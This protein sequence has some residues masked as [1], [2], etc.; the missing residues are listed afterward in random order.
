VALA[1]DTKKTSTSAADSFDD[2]TDNIAKNDF[3]LTG[4]GVLPKHFAT[5][6]IAILE[7]GSRIRS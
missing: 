3:T 2:L 6:G 5:R 1:L 4:I 7:E